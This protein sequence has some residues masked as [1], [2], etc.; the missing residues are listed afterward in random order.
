MRY[1]YYSHIHRFMRRSFADIEQIIATTD[2]SNPAQVK[3]LEEKFSSFM[4]L[5]EQ[6]AGHEDH[7]FHPMIQEDEPALF[8]E[9]T[10]EHEELDIKLE[11]LKKLLEDATAAGLSEE[12]QHE[13]GYQ[14]YLA[15]TDYMS[16]YFKHLLHEERMVMAALHE[17][18]SDHELREINFDI[19]NQ[20]SAEQMI[21]MLSHIYPSLNRY[22]RQVFLDDIFESCPDKFAKVFPAILVV[23]KDAGE[24]EGLSKKYLGH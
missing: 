7:V 19:Y 3:H 1:R 16:D 24:R 20:M 9:I 6:H 11:A 12:E 5:L 17:H 10:L 15:Y 18:Y 4:A 13:C 21:G 23:I 22:E 14:F 2:F 8:H